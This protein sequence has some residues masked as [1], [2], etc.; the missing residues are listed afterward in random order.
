MNAAI[1]I[2]SRPFSN[3]DAGDAICH[4]VSDRRF[5]TDRC[6]CA[7]GPS[8]TTRWLS[9]RGSIARGW[10]RTCR[11]QKA[12]MSRKAVSAAAGQEAGAGWP[13]GRGRPLAMQKQCAWPGYVFTVTARPVAH[14]RSRRGSGC[15]SATMHRHADERR[16]DDRPNHCR[17]RE[18]PNTTTSRGCRLGARIGVCD[19]RQFQSHVAD[20]LP[21]LLRV[22]L[23]TA[24]QLTTKGGRRVRGQRGPCG[25]ER[26]CGRAPRR[27]R[28]S[29]LCAKLRHA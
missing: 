7:I 13:P 23:K 11:R 22:L 29:A 24:T 20:V 27:P 26:Q 1:G 25:G 12:S 15:P 28:R 6:Y 3:D 2:R 8:R 10:V 4:R 14:D 19:V 21:S 18:R 17:G 16:H 9:R 5:A